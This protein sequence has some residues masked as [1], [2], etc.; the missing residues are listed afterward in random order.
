[1][2]KVV[3]VCERF[4]NQDVTLEPIRWDKD[5]TRGE[6]PNRKVAS[7]RKHRGLTREEVRTGPDGRKYIEQFQGGIY[8]TDDPAT[9]KQMRNLP[10]YK[11]GIIR[12]TKD[13]DLNQPFINSN[14]LVTQ[15]MVGSKPMPPKES[16]ES[17]EESP[18]RES[19]VKV[20]KRR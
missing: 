9:I 14:T 5:G 4:P 3:F 12:E 17:P 8:V 19:E 16:F 6:R 18:A 13:I 10:E 2:E 7:F 20:L 11:T 15:G 1:M